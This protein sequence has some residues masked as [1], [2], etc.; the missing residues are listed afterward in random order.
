[1][2]Q[3]KNEISSSFQDFVVNHWLDSYDLS[4]QQRDE[5]RFGPAD[6]LERPYPSGFTS[7]PFDN[8]KPNE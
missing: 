6:L 5:V 1:M 2:E 3:W 7:C 8:N 4:L